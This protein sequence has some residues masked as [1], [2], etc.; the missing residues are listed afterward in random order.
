[1]SDINQD[2]TTIRQDMRAQLSQVTPEQRHDASADSNCLGR[3]E[4]SPP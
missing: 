1:M 3:T 2:K 4:G